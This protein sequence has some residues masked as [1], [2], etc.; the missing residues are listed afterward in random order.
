M[1]GVLADLLAVPSATG[2][3]LPEAGAQVGA[4]EDGVE[5]D[6]GQHEDE[7]QRR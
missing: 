1:V 4:G 2:E 6:A 7:R 5:H 3:E